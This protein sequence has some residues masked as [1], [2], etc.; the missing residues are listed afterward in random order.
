[1]WTFP[2]FPE[3]ASTVAGTVDLL[4]LVLIGLASF[5]ALGVAV[6]LV[7]FAIH[8][9]HGNDKADRTGIVNSNLRLEVLWSL[10]PLLL[11][12]GVFGWGAMTYVD[13]KRPPPGEPLEIYVVAK[14]WMWKFQHPNGVRE[15]NDLHLPEGRPVKF[16]MTSQDV[17][18]SLYVPAFRLK[19]DVLPGRYTDLWV[20]P[21]RAGVYHLFCTEYCGTE[22]S[23]MGGKAIVMEPGDYERW[24]REGATDGSNTEPGTGRFER[25]P[26]GAEDAPVNP[27]PWGAARPE[28]RSD[29]PLQGMAARG[30]ALFERLRC[31]TC[32]RPDSTALY[33]AQGPSLY[34]LYGSEVRLQNNR[35]VTA[36][37]HYLR[38]SILYPQARLVLGYPPIMPTFKGQITEDELMDLVAYLKSLGTSPFDAA[39]SAPAA[40]TLRQP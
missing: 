36:D 29:A 6:L 14:Q 22:H 15:I 30:E 34:R 19:Q 10:G 5:F 4:Y 25:A 18:H 32:H 35:T 33:P 11:S 3:Q 17:I 37:E 13:I 26:S 23:Y 28:A 16:I 21:S 2:L 38:E 7:G 9:R 20:E 12:L 40:D 31:T 8:Y 24:L 27:G 39:P 1:M